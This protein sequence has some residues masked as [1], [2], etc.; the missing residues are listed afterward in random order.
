MQGSDDSNAGTYR[1]PTTPDLRKS[2]LLGPIRARQALH[3]LEDGARIDV[4][5][6]MGYLCSRNHPLLDTLG[7]SLFDRII[8]YLNQEDVKT[9]IPHFCTFATGAVRLLELTAHFRDPTRRADLLVE[10]LDSFCNEF[11]YALAGEARGDAGGRGRGPDPAS[12][13]GDGREQE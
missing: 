3:R 13:G 1:G 5:D 11:D 6:G 7:W 12:A 9:E 10:D 8:T 4:I 2:R